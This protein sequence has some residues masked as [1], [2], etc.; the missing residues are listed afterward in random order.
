MKRYQLDD[1]SVVEYLQVVVDGEEHHGSFTI[2]RV[3]RT[4]SAFDVSFRDLFTGIPACSTTLRWIRCDCMLDSFW[5]A[6]FVNGLEEVLEVYSL[7]VSTRN[8][9]P[10]GSSGLLTQLLSRNPVGR[11]IG[12]F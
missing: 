8:A 2:R 7:G 3:D 5:N 9:E 6:W 1:G 12:V 11:Q 4:K 10:C